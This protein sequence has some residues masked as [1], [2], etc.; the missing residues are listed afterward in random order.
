MV[1]EAKG[2]KREM[3]Y[4]QHDKIIEYKNSHGGQR[5]P[6]NKSDW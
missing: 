6:L 3:H 2:S 1:F 5:P 4:W